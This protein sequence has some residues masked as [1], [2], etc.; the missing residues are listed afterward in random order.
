MMTPG[1]KK[2][3]EILYR[4]LNSIAS[5]LKKELDKERGVAQGTDN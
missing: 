2:L 4:G 3:Y 1:E 5:M